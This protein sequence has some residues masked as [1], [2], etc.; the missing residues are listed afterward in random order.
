MTNRVRSRHDLPKALGHGLNFSEPASRRHRG[1][2]PPEDLAPA[3]SSS[4]AAGDDGGVPL[5]LAL[6]RPGVLRSR[7]APPG[8]A[9]PGEARTLSPTCA[10]PST[11][12]SA[13]STARSSRPTHPFGRWQDKANPR[14]PLLP[15]REDLRLVAQRQLTCAC[16]WCRHRGPGCA[17]PDAPGRLLHPPRCGTVDLIPFWDGATRA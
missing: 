9:R 15:E 5:G 16:T 13:A 11:A 4:T 10:E 3:I 14:R 2:G 1:G 17:R 6:G 12:S 7:R 8:S